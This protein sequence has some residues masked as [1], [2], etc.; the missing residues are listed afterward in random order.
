MK[1]GVRGP[2]VADDEVYRRRT[3][4]TRG[5]KRRGRKGRR[6]VGLPKILTGDG[7]ER[8]NGRGG[9]ACPAFL[10]GTWA[11][12]Y[13]NSPREGH[14]VPQFPETEMKPLEA[15]DRTLRPGA[16]TSGFIPAQSVTVSLRGSAD[17]TYGRQETLDRRWRIPPNC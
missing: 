6:K 14:D 11:K 9:H 1:D 16:T 10:G 4:G 17:A 15:A 3:E 13:N 12:C 2:A 5:K 7:D 8:C